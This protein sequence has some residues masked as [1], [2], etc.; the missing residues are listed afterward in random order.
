MI[1]VVETGL[2]NKLDKES[3]CH[4]HPL[5]TLVDQTE[6][7][8][9]TECLNNHFSMASEQLHDCNEDCRQNCSSCFD[10]Y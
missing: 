2:K 10:S 8:K 7:N 4:I 6:V 5:T 9:N 3:L 1:V